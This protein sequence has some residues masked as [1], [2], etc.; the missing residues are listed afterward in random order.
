[1]AWLADTNVK[2][3]FRVKVGLTILMVLLLGLLSF[4]VWSLP[5]DYEGTYSGDYSGDD[6]GIWI[7]YVNNSGYMRFITWSD[8]H[9][10][11]DGGQAFVVDNGEIDLET[12]DETDVIGDIDDNDFDVE[13]DWD[14]PSG[15]DGDFSGTQQDPGQVDDYADDYDEEFCG[16]A[17]GTWEITVEN[18]GYVSGH[19]Y[20]SDGPDVFVEGGI[21]EDGTFIL[22]TS[23]DAGIRG[24]IQ[25]DGDVTGY[26]RNEEDAESGYI[27]NK[28][29]CGPITSELGDGGGGGC[30]ISVLFD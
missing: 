6:N 10:S 22:Y 9:K 3:Q 26:W 5:G 2:G 4:P 15:D 11:V 23:D 14:N 29:T 19:V 21:N 28:D 18:T 12:D 24:T 30:F 27:S 17:D 1:M 7:A 25:S 20:P 16:D 8:D 13:G